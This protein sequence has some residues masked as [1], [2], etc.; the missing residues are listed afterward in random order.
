ME[1]GRYVLIDHTADVGVAV[2][3]P[4]LEGVFETAA[5]ALFDILVESDEAPAEPGPV[6]VGVRVEGADLEEVL[7]RWLAE[8]LYLHDTRGLVFE[9]FEVTEAD[10]GHAAGRARG[11]PFDP[12]RHRR[13]TELKAVTYHQARV[14][15][16]QG[17]WEARVIFD[18]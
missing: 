7:V 4:T 1:S 13:R 17:G 12:S 11:G 2:T 18:V 3:A 8:L 10:S 16:A 6:V 14:A 15:S 9:R 5:T